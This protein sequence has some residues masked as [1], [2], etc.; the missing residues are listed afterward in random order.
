MMFGVDILVIIEG[1]VELFITAVVEGAVGQED[2]AENGRQGF[3]KLVY[4]LFRQ[5][6]LLKKVIFIIKIYHL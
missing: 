6:I 2:S 1:R 3:Y 4:Q 5:S